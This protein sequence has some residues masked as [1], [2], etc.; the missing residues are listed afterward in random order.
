MILKRRDELDIRIR[1][2][3]AGFV[4]GFVTA[5]LLIMMSGAL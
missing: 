4:A 2:S 5:C 3:F 1:S